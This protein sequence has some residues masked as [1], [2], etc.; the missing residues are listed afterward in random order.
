MSMKKISHEEFEKILG[1]YGSYFDFCKANPDWY[2]R[3]LHVD[4]SVFVEDEHTD[5][6]HELVFGSEREA[7]A[8]YNV[9][10][11][12]SDVLENDKTLDADLLKLLYENAD[13]AEDAVYL[14]KLF[15]DELKKRCNAE[16][17]VDLYHYIDEHGLSADLLNYAEETAIQRARR[18]P[19]F[20]DHNS[21]YELF[22]ELKYF[23]F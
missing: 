7:E 8:F 18:N 10:K 15:V 21:V 17:L 6:V 4:K 2:Q 16:S 12:L 13:I 1:K 20:F 22:N 23:I 11:F 3:V 19:A 14:L 9:L 5:D